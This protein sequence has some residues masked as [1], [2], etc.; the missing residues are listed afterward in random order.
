MIE[1]GKNNLLS[2][3]TG[4]H[5]NIFYLKDKIVESNTLHEK[6]EAFSILMREGNNSNFEQ[7]LR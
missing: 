7:M 2:P 5:I 6:F 3:R 1:H 4:R